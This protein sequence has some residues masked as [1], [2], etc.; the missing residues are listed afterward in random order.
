MDRT[1]LSLAGLKLLH[2]VVLAGAFVV[3]DGLG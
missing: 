1:G 2:L 3:A